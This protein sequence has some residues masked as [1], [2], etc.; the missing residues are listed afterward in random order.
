[1]NIKKT[2]I[3]CGLVAAI[4]CAM[5][6]SVMCGVRTISVSDAVSALGGSTASA[7]EAAAYLRVPRTVLA[8]F[9]GA[10]LAL[11]GT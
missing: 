1:M 3:V 10:A 9:V 5:V 11:A 6:A 7:G 4:A 2:A 8:L